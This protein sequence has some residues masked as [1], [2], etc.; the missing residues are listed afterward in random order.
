MERNIVNIIITLLIS[1]VFT[2][3][4]GVF[5]SDK[6]SGRV[7]LKH[8]TNMV[9]SKDSLEYELIIIDPGFDLWL[10]RNNYMRGQYENTY[11]QNM[12]GIYT[13]IWNQLYMTGDRRVES[14]IDYDMKIDYGFEFNYKLFMYFKYF[15]DVNKINLR[16]GRRR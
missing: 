1:L 13:S 8:D 5:Q 12:N 16:T 7:G 2:V 15:E 11:L 4:C 10:L 3:S 6:M 14:Y 9:E